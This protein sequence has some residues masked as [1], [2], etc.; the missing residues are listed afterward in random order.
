MFL[1]GL[2]T[3]LLTIFVIS[4]HEEFRI[5]DDRTEGETISLKR[6]WHFYKGLYQGIIACLIGIA[7][8]WDLSLLFCTL[9]TIY[10]DAWINVRVLDKPVDFVGQT[11]WFDKT[12]KKIFRKD[13]N[14][15]IFKILVGMA[16][17]AFIIAERF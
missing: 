4:K 9:F 1:V 5:K 16:S 14:V 17:L 8:G 6:K 11:A 10:H 3:V 2:L 15:F 13:R 7:F 12:L